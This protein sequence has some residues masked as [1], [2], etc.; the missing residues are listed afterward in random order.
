[1][2]LVVADGGIQDCMFV[3]GHTYLCMLHRF[4]AEYDTVEILTH[5]DS[6]QGGATSDFQCR[7]LFKATTCLSA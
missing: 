2:Y 7:M 5:W 6:A 1:M 4:R 3:P